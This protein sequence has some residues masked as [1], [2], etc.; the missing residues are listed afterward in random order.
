MWGKY[1]KA[2]IAFLFALWT[3]IAPQLT[4]DGKWDLAEQ[5]VFAVAVGN[6]LLVWIIPLNP[7][8]SAGKTIINGVLS[9]LAAAQLVIFDGI[10]PD[11]WTI[12]IG[13]FLSVVMGWVAPT[14][15]MR[16]TTEQV[17]V[18]SGFTS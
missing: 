13:A 9:A 6:G 3:V 17:K 16:G 10:Q 8:W 2:I 4:G 12:I 1:G 11:D 15:S 7:A 18:T 5:L 14:H